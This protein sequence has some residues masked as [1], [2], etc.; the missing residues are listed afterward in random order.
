M[1]DHDDSSPPTALVAGA[2]AVLALAA[3]AT[4]A[5]SAARREAIA[6]G[7]RDKADVLFVI[8]DSPGM[9]PKQVEL[10]ARLPAL[11]RTLDDAAYGGSPVSY[12]F[13]VVSTDLGAGRY[14]IGS[15]CV[16]GGKQGKLIRVGA[17][18]SAA[19]VG[20]G[21]GLGYIDYDQRLGTSNL[22]PGQDLATT[23][24]CMASLGD[25]GCGFEQPLEAAYRA[26]HDHL[27]ENDG[28]LRDDALLVVV[29]VTDEDDCSVDAGSDLFDPGKA[30]TYGPLRSYRCSNYGVVCGAPPAL[31]PYGSSGGAL[32]SCRA[33][34]SAEGGKLI[35]IKK[36]VDFFGR[37]RAQG[38]LEDDPRDVVLVGLTGPSDPVSTLL[39]KPTPTPSGAY[40]PCAGPPDGATCA[41]AL[42]RSCAGA[43]RVGDPAIRLNQVIHAEPA[44][45]QQLGSI[46]DASYEPAMH[47]LGERIVAST[48][49]GPACLGGPLEDPTRPDCVVED[50]GHGADGSTSVTSLPSC[51]Q[52]APP[53]W[54]LAQDPSCPARCVASGDPAQQLAVVV[55]RGG[56][57]A[58]GVDTRV[59]CAT[60]PAG[61]PGPT[62]GPPIGP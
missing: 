1:R 6:K 20:P 54:R 37:P 38:G 56:V 43:Q 27:H 47:G 61:D 28:F 30:G 48:A 15:Q 55:D 32:A 17:A 12:H 33:A 21:A 26:L 35:G 60:I 7:P 46:C 10:V 4:T 40:V 41:V 19:C 44:G 58:P 25:A 16:P 59:A 50:V 29:F 53:C 52:A 24:G 34:T 22:P 3:C 31:L 39:A 18:A 14:T 36:Y 9:R 23:L 42:Q 57:P 11:V 45:N 5:E 8:D 49:R 2:L 13:G 62:C 51:A